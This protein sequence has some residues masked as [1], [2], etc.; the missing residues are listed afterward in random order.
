MNGIATVFGILDTA[1]TVLAPIVESA[2]DGDT[3]AGRVARRV[4]GVVGTAVALGNELVQADE[5]LAM[6]L[7]ALKLEL[8]AIQGR[9][10]VEQS[11]MTALAHR[12]TE[13]N[14]ELQRV[15]AERRQMREEAVIEAEDL[16]MT[17]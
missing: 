2:A 10:G 13:A 15:V 9:G 7:D 14:A 8:E 6:R 1:V 12:S 17:A 16:D 11:D 5:R 4:L 3:K